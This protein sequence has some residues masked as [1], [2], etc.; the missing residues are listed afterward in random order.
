MVDRREDF[1]IAK[2]FHFPDRFHMFLLHRYMLT[3]SFTPT[4][5]PCPC[6]MLLST[7]SRA[8]LPLL[9]LPYQNHNC[10]AMCSLPSLP[11]PSASTSAGV[12]FFW[13]PGLR[14]FRR[15][16]CPRLSRPPPPRKYRPTAD[17][18]SE[19]CCKDGRTFQEAGGHQVERFW[20]CEGE[21]LC[22]CPLELQSGWGFWGL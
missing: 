1:K 14:F 21:A 16:G 12:R 8:I 7:L 18:K 11:W 9:H 22:A 10:N 17:F 6:P 15:P 20:V 13:L 2:S 19:D 4:E 5:N 3:C